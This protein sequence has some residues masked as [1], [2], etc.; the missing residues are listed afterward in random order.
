MYKRTAL[1]TDKIGASIVKERSGIGPDFRERSL[2]KRLFLRERSHFF[3][4]IKNFNPSSFS[5]VTR[6]FVCKQIVISFGVL[7]VLKCSF[8]HSFLFVVDICLLTGYK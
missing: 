1:V 5:H 3:G 4:I 8:I 6:V 2:S 7:F